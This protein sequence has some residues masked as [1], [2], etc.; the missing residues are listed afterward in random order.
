[1]TYMNNNLPRNE[2]RRALHLR[3]MAL[4]AAAQTAKA[5]GMTT[6]T[7]RQVE[8]LLEAN[9]AEFSALKFTN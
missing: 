8:L 2:T 7:Y 9:A 3:R 4:H 1:M 5:D 6:G